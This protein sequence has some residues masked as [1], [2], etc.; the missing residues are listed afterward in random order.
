GILGLV[1]PPDAKHRKQPVPVKLS[2]ECDTCDAA[3]QDLQDHA[4]SAGVEIGLC[5]RRSHSE[6][7]GRQ[8]ETKNL[9]SCTQHQP[10]PRLAWPPSVADQRRQ[11]FTLG[12]VLRN[13]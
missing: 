9:S 7:K 3:Q 10:S 12:K 2:R 1:A 13:V 11:R 6:R 4:A 5:G 8:K